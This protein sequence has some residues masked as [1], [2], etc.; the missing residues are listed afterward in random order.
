MLPDVGAGHVKTYPVGDLPERVD[1]RADPRVRGSDEVDVLAV[2]QRLIEYELVQARATAEH[3]LVAQSGC[4][5]ISTMS[6]AS[7]RSC[8]TATSVGQGR[9][10][11]HAWIA[12]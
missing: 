3:Q 11:D 6:L 7:T 10:V 8:S 5:A 9:V 12:A 1:D 2:A 4:R